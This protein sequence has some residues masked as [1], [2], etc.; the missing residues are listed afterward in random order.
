MPSA[1]MIGGSIDGTTQVQNNSVQGGYTTIGA[2]DG[3]RCLFDSGDI[4]A[5]TFTLFGQKA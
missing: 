2:Y 4:N 3:I 1:T 5:G